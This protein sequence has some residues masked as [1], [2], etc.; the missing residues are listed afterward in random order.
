MKVFPNP[1]TNDDFLNVTLDE[2][3]NA[4]VKI[5]LFNMAGQTVYSEEISDIGQDNMH[6]IKLEGIERG[7]YYLKAE[8]DGKTGV[9]KVIVQ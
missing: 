8:S 6:R 7:L 4:N 2:S 1:A 9:Q 3:L 5:T